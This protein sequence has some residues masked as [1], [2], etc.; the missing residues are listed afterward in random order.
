MVIYRFRLAD[1]FGAALWL[2][3]FARV[4][5][6][7]DTI[8]FLAQHYLFIGDDFLPALVELDDGVWRVSVEQGRQGQGSEM[9]PADDRLW[10]GLHRAALDRVETPDGTRSAAILFARELGESVYDD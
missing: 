4:K 7:A 9:D 8:S 2:Q 10:R 6:L 5:R 1:I 3:L